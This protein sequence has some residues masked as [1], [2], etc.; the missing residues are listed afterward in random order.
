M[1][2]VNKR[3][4]RLRKKAK[5]S[6]SQLGKAVGVSR[7]AISSWELGRSTPK[8]RWLKPLAKALGCQIT[9]LL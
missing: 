3:I 6:Q 2:M 8:A 7:C 9:D 4:A 1:Q 5:M